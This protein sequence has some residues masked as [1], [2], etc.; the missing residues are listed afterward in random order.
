MH[1]H[2]AAVSRSVS[3]TYAFDEVMFWLSKISADL[4]LSI[5]TSYLQVP[6]V[7]NDVLVLAVT[8]V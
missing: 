8:A 3:C 1:P 7:G 2:A 6:R 4:L 5:G